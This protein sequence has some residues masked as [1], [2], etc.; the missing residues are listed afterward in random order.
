MAQR[1][2]IFV[3]YNSS[4]NIPVQVDLT[5]TISRLKQEIARQQKVDPSGI[6]I[7]F[8]GREL[9]DDVVLKDCEIPNQS[10]IHAVQGGATGISVD[11]TTVPLSSITL[12]DE[13]GTSPID[14]IPGPSAARPA[15][16]YVY[17]REC[18]GV[19]PGKLRVGCTMC[20][21]GTLVLNQ[22]PQGWEDV[23]QRG[24]IKGVCQKSGCH[25]KT[26]EFYFKCGTH[27]ASEGERS[28]ALYLIRTNI[29]NVPCLACQEIMDPVLV[30]P[31]DVGHAMCLEC[32]G[33]YCETRLNDRQFVQNENIGYTLPCPGDTDSCSS[34]FIEEA[35]HF[36]VLGQNQYERYQR[37]GTEEYVLQTGGVLCPG[38]GCGMGLY[39]PAGSR[40]IRCEGGCRGE[41][42]RQCKEAY[43]RGHV[44]PTQRSQPTAEA[45]RQS[46]YQVSADSARRARWEQEEEE[47]RSLIQQI[48]K[49]CPKC[50]VATE[51][52]GG[53]NHMTCTRCKYE[54]CWLCCIRWNPECQSNHWFMQERRR[55]RR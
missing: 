5:W 51:K 47:A 18:K 33:M 11:A 37:F 6:R 43:Q 23:L 34:A 55:G 31:C 21:E 15:Q 30:F 20:K 3:R 28:V 17:C 22:D 53:C 24:R 8:A 14:S 35:H 39:P 38:P 13:G 46:R 45:A 52:S 2:H 41:F 40:T 29:R 19:K 7:I 36:R 16:Y 54:W 44:C 1:F 9:K 10:I 12:N 27:R 50:K 32:F 25:G 42:C 48:S 26:A 4:T 49:N